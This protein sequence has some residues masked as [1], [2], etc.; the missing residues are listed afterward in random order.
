VPRGER[1]SDGAAS[2]VPDQVR[3]LDLE[4]VHHAEQIVGHLVDRI[5]DAR[6]AALARAAV[7]VNDDLMPLREGGDVRHPVAADA[8][9]PRHQQ[10]GRPRSMRFVMDITIAERG[11]RHV[12]PR[13]DVADAPLVAID[14][15]GSAPD[16]EVIGLRM[17]RRRSLRG[18]IAP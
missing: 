5:A 14:C 8:S 11:L 9:E 7:I 18:L 3:L 2:R 16:R 1:L 6:P 12:G 4:M 13:A 15:H 10:D 17:D